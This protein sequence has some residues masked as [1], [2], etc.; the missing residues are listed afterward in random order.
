MIIIA[1]RI[2]G[3]MRSLVVFRCMEPMIFVFFKV[4]NNRIG[5]IIVSKK[6]II[7]FCKRRAR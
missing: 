3:I 2:K 1:F 4:M 6:T 5:K 7:T